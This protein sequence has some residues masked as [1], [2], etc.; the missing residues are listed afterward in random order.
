MRM[1]GLETWREN[2]G[3]RCPSAKTDTRVLFFL[4]LLPRGNP[5]MRMN[6]YVAMYLPIPKVIPAA[7]GDGHEVS[8]VFPRKGSPLRVNP[9]SKTLYRMELTLNPL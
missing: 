5:A 8:M 2:E 3:T 4:V 9:Q 6:W 7:V 1:L